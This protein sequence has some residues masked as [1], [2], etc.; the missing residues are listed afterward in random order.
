MWR[1][2]FGR[3]LASLRPS[4]L[5]KA[6][7]QSMARGE[8]PVQAV[9]SFLAEKPLHTLVWQ[10]RPGRLVGNQALDPYVFTCTPRA[11]VLHRVVIFH[12]TRARMGLAKTKSRSEVSYSGRKVRPQKGQ[13]KA[14]LGDRS[15]P[16]QRGG[17]KAF[18]KRPIDYSHHKT[19]QKIITLG[20]RMAITLKFVTG[21]F[22]VID[23]LEMKTEDP[24][25][26]ES[27]IRPWLPTKDEEDLP[28]AP[29]RGVLVI[30]GGSYQFPR[31]EVLI[32]TA[33]A[34]KGHKWCKVQCIRQLNVYDILRQKYLVVTTGALR[35]IHAHFYPL[36]MVQ[37]PLWY[38]MAHP[39]PLPVKDTQWIHPGPPEFTA[40]TAFS[41]TVAADTLK[42]LRA[43][44]RAT[45]TLD[46]D[47]DD[48]DESEEREA[49]N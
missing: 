10:L 15:S 43:S 1:L 32:N 28:F 6:Y 48:D 11:D 49:V 22:V 39:P 2:P 8:H 36:K 12:Q 47:D 23:D 35:Q 41:S 19:P 33:N 37:A 7:V 3:L 18:P 16:L 29:S 17:A 20:L 27:L 9:Y 13:G 44:H 24:L 34:A 40:F 26:L 31:T 45:K 14:R 5:Q 42:A 21:R 4:V 38:Q 25:E 30:D 46:D